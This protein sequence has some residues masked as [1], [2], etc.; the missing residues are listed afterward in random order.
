MHTYILRSTV[1]ALYLHKKA[2]NAFSNSSAFHCAFVTGAVILT[3]AGFPGWMTCVSLKNEL[4]WFVSHLLLHSL[5]HSFIHTPIAVWS[6]TSMTCHWCAV[7]YVYQCAYML[8]ILLL[9]TRSYTPHLTSRQ[10]CMYVCAHSSTALMR[11]VVR[12]ASA[13]AA[14]GVFFLYVIVSDF[15]SFAMQHT[16]KLSAVGERQTYICS[17]CVSLNGFQSHAVECICSI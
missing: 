7:I 16:Y 4:N 13:D 9:L 15:C 10:T 6:S 17:V 8:P 3:Y 12:S 1:T 14:P 5:T 11:A 2:S